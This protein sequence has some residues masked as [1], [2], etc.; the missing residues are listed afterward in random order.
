VW[1]AGSALTSFLAANPALARAAFVEVHA[2][3][4]AAIQV[5]YDRVGAFTMFLE[6]GY[7]NREQT[8]GLPRSCSEPLVAVIFEYFYRAARRDPAAADLPTTLPLIVYLC[9]AP[10]IGANEAA[11][12]V[13]AMTKDAQRTKA[14]HGD[15]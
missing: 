10:F 15:P 5:V 2:I 7:R 4:P 14:G 9:I 1:A 3:S 8:G 12:F 6:E 11:D 13:H